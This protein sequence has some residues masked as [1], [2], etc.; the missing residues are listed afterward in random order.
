MLA[1]G[2]DQI[3]KEALDARLAVLGNSEKD[4]GLWNMTGLLEQDEGYQRLARSALS[5]GGKSKWLVKPG[6]EPRDFDILVA[7]P[8]AAGWEAGEGILYHAALMAKA[9]GKQGFVLL[10]K[11]DRINWVG[12]RFVDSGELGIPASSVVMADDVIAALSPHIRSTEQ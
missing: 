11:R 4:S 10:P 3:W 7:G 1:K 8:E 2:E 6:K 5:G 9:R 12:L